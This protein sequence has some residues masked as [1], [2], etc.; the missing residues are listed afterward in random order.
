MK[1]LM[2]QEFLKLRFK[3]STWISLIIAVG[4]MVLTGLTTLNVGSS[5]SKYYFSSAYGGFQWFII[6]LIAI[7]ASSIT[8]EFQFGTIKHLVIQADSRWRVYYIKL[9]AI[10]CYN[11]IGHII[12][13]LAAVL[14]KLLLYPGLDLFSHYHYG[15]T[16]IVNLILNGTLDF[17]L[18]YLFIGM[19]TLI[20]CISSNSAVAV[21]VGIGVAF[22]GEG[23]SNMVLSSFPSIIPIMRWNPFNMLNFQQQFAYPEHIHDTHL[24]LSQ[25]GIGIFVWSCLF[26]ILGQLLFQRRKI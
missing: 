2:Y 12:I 14:I 23:L 7:N 18:S 1:P 15:S 5:D 9:L 16:V 3:K 22:A 10:S 11:F 24:L 20:A 6:V 25:M 4:M 17:F 26:L 19:V 21:S 8:S 13:F